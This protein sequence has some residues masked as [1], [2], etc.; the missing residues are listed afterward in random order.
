M[1]LKNRILSTA[2]ASSAAFIS[3]N[4]SA[5]NTYSQNFEGLDKDAV[6]A[7]EADGWKIFGV[8]PVGQYGPFPAPN[9]GPA[10]SAID[11]GQGG[12]DQ[13]AQQLSIYSDYNNPNHDPIANNGPVVTRVFQEQFNNITATDVGNTWYWSFDYKSG[14]IEGA[15][16][17]GAFITTLDPNNGYASTNDFSFTTGT[18]DLWQSGFLSLTIDDN[19]IGNILQ[20]GFQTSAD[21]YQGSG[22]FYDNVSFSQ[23]SPVPLP[24]AAWLFGSAL[25]GLVAARRKK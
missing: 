22:V 5:V 17:A 7:L 9:G 13:G 23:T 20:Y 16:T 24:A 10:F 18:S 3:L 25:A 1:K 2:I 21:L 19:L 11:A 15:S 4:A 8:D 14:N 6:N 12:V